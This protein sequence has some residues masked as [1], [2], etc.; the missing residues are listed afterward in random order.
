MR[1]RLHV[2]EWAGE[3][4]GT[5]WH[6]FIG[7]FAVV[8]G[9]HPASPLVHSV[10]VAAVRRLIV[11]LLFV[12]SAVVVPLTPIGRRSGGHVNPAVTFAFFLRRHLHRRDLAGYI[13]AQLLG[14]IAGAALAAAVARGVVSNVGHA[15]TH[16]Q[17]GL[18]PWT[19]VAIEALETAAILLIVFACVSHPRTMRFTPLAVWL[20][21]SAIICF[22]AP[23]TGA[24]INPARSL[25]PAV[26]AG[27]LSSYWVYVAGPL[28]GAMLAAAAWH[29]TGLR[30]TLTAKLFHDR[31]RPADLSERESVKAG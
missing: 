20:A 23:L 26:A 18:S 6:V 15:R 8:L 29:V 11:G 30:P 10:H 2:T 25:G 24:S 4:V 7:T 19:A 3:F 1:N 31:Q 14:G 17:S 9:F 28:L 22:L 27:D 5:A 12:G 16:P 13:A 21:L